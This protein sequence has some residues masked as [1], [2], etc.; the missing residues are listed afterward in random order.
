[1]CFESERKVL[2]PDLII[3]NPSNLGFKNKKKRK[4]KKGKK[5]KEQGSLFYKRLAQ[6]THNAKCYMIWGLTQNL[7]HNR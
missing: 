3:L 5:K 2:N 7:E 1:M 4:K 6:I